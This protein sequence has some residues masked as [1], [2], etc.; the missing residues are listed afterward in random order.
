MRSFSTGQF[1]GSISK[2]SI[3]VLPNYRELNISSVNFSVN[4]TNHR[5]QWF[6]LLR[7]SLYVKT[8]DVIRLRKEVWVHVISCRLLHWSGFSDGGKIRLIIFHRFTSSPHL[9]LL[10]RKIFKHPFCCENAAGSIIISVVVLSTLLSENFKP[11]AAGKFPNII[12]LFVFRSCE[13]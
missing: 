3:Q 4:I 8:S 6:I 2:R 9:N 12:F 13:L 7:V 1:I 5:H 11:A 10:S